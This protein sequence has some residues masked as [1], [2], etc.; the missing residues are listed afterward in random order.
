MEDL[1][2]IPA[3]VFWAML[4]A[5]L[6]PFVTALLVRLDATK[7][8]KASVAS[9]L[10]LLDAV[11][12]AWK[13]ASDAGTT[14]SAPTLIAAIMGAVMWQRVVHTQV[15]DAYRIPEKLPAGG[16]VG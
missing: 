6:V 11:L 12:V 13:Q 14:M 4:V 10:A 16:L 15:N 1:T 9:G 7:A 8:T 2:I 3:P 5:T